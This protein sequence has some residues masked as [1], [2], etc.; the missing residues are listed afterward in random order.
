MIY[1]ASK[2]YCFDRS[3]APRI[4]LFTMMRWLWTEF[5]VSRGFTL[6]NRMCLLLPCSS[7]FM[8]DSPTIYIY[9][10][11]I[12]LSVG[13]IRFSR[14]ESIASA[15]M[16]FHILLFPSIFFNS[17]WLP[18]TSNQ[19]K[20]IDVEA[21][22]KHFLWTEFPIARWRAVTRS[23]SFYHLFIFHFPHSHSH[24]HSHF[25]PSF[26]GV[27]LPN[28]AVILIKLHFRKKKK[29]KKKWNE[30]MATTADDNH[31]QTQ[32]KYDENPH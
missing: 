20:V 22:L 24:S 13:V 30:N 8:L 7:F 19:F 28:I 9:I 3:R 29:R 32:K 26:M 11:C 16:P 14:R 21:T 31:G 4:H 6:W 25:R 15:L 17:L 23:A 5:V 1:F 10:H 12:H 2:V 18:V 27:F